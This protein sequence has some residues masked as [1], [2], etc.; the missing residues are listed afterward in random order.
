MTDQP[1]RHRRLFVG[2]TLALAAIGAG[3]I[4]AVR[5]PSSPPP[6]ALPGCV[7]T[8]KG[9][10]ARTWN[11][12]I[13][14]AIRQDFPAPTVHARNL[15]HLSAAMWD[16]WVAY[17]PTAKAYR[18][19]ERATLPASRAAAEAASEEAISY[20]AATLLRH[21]YEHAVNAK[22]SLAQFDATL[23]AL[24]FPAQADPS[25]A[26]SMLGVRIGQSYVDLGRTDGSMEDS[27]YVDEAY[28]SVNDP[29]VIAQPGTVMKDPNRWQ[30]L[31]MET[32]ITQNG[33]QQPTNTQTYV[34]AQWGN[35]TPFALQVTG[36]KLAIDPGP[37][38]RLGD[39]ATDAAFKA[40]AVETLRASAALGPNDD[41]SMDI[42]P[43]TIGNNPLG[44]NDGKGHPANP[45]T[46][47]AYAPNVVKRS[48]FTRVLA[49]FWADGPKS[50]TPPGH[51]NVLA[52]QV[53]DQLGATNPSSL[54]VG[55]TGPV[56]D[57][58]EW[59]IKLYFALNGATHDAAIA[60]WGLKR[61]YESARPL[62]MVRYMGAKGQSTDPTQPHYDPAGLPLVPGLI[63][64]VTA[65]TTATG[66][67]HAALAGHEGEIAV[68]A[69]RGQPADITTQVGGVG[70]I[71]AVDW[72]TYQR[73][74]F[75]TPAFPGFVSGHS[76]FSRAAAEVLT[77]MTGSPT[78]PGGLGST[79]LKAGYLHFES[80]PSADVTLQWATYFDA[81][82]QAGQS[83]IWG[84]IHIGVDDV[85]GR[86][87]G[88]TVGQS[89]WAKARTYFHN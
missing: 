28:R 67:R 36:E 85:T 34:G 40:G 82:D 89:A 12:A 63:E 19:N 60:A 9:S 27:L 50:E 47:H 14:T 58:L 83:R 23:Q 15:F 17:H 51:W 4:L 39:P 77:A 66:Q 42:S 38:P 49:E 31:Q 46:G 2:L 59:D 10:V 87:I 80:G 30:P 26:A 71:R 54:R 8:A 56:L 7:R 22:Q 35:V 6:E 75:V 62:S 86:R 68:Y 18:V 76:T 53:S 73:K 43:G 88:A 45:A 74:T 1:S 16:A 81:A 57:R 78:F 61:E 44:T 37:P 72:L 32:L 24:C 20:A 65:E 79:T 13:L 41:V 84:G 25:R 5:R 55:N 21:R 52:N 33:L 64:V 69:W 48:D 70:W 11:E 29:L 3:T